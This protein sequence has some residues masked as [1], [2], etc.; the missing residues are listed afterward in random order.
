MKDTI[1]LI[2]D[3]DDTLAPDSTSGFLDEM[4]IDVERFWR[5]KVDALVN[6]GW[7]PVPAYLYQMVKSSN[8]NQP[9]RKFTRQAFREW[10]KKVTFYPGATQIFQKLRKHADEIASDKKVQIE[11]EYYIISTG[12]GD[13]VGNTRIKGNFT[14]IWA[15]NFHYSDSGE[16]VFPKNI[17]SFTDK[18]RF[19]FQI[20]KGII[21]REYTGKPFE[22][23]KKLQPDDY[24]IPFNRMIFVGD[25]FTDVPCFSLIQKNQGIA[26]GVYDRNKREKWRQAWGF[27]EDGRVANLAVADYS[28][29]SGL[30][31]SLMM[32]VE[33]MC[34][35]IALSRRIYQG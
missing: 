1:A 21:G 25:G 18:T 10:G 5:E 9:D 19:L 2:F 35:K 7:D 31:D 8:E 23:N 14:Q 16:I 30:H 22:V 29:G 27:V 6:Q 13:I 33:I 24:R 3:F 32:A 28:K 26:I 11:I 34:D 20:S 17:V 4:G 12:I 15:S